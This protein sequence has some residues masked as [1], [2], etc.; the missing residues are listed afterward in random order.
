MSIAV[1]TKPVRTPVKNRT[2]SEERARQYIFEDLMSFEA[3][4]EFRKTPFFRSTNNVWGKG[5]GARSKIGGVMDAVK[6]LK[7]GATIE[8]WIEYYLSNV[9]TAAQ[10]FYFIDDF[11]VDNDY[12]WEDAVNIFAVY[13]WDIAYEGWSSEDICSNVIAEKF[14]WVAENVT[15]DEDADYG[16]DRLFYDEDDKLVCAVQMKPV[17]YLYGNGAQLVREREV[18]N[19]RKNQKFE[20]RYGV[21]VFYTTNESCRDGNPIMIPFREAA[22]GRSALNHGAIIV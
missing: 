17:S 4:R 14:G 10:F 22:K 7:P 5:Y 8:D 15:S 9:R 12:F 16:I 19:P 11:A 13:A 1:E 21:P 2:I 20:D 3:R 6:N 18:I